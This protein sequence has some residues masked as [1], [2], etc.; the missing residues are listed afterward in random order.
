MAKEM[1]CSPELRA[2]VKHRKMERKK[3]LSAIWKYAK[4]HKLQSKESGQIIECDKKLSAVFKKVIA[5]K[6]K[7]KSRGK[8]LRIPAGSLFMTEMM[9][10][11]SKHFS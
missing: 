2:V 3:V 6:R 7:I 8:T 10:A 4:K 11:L 1:K 9:G 5:K